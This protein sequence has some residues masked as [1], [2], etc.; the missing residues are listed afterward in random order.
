MRRVVGEDPVREDLQGDVA[1]QVHVLRPVDDA[2]ATVAD[3]LE[4]L[5][6]PEG[7]TDHGTLRCPARGAR[8][9]LADKAAKKGQSTR[10][11]IP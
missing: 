6:V 4:D 5:I 2:H 3:L 7:G 8:R 10:S 9:K 1:P 11:P